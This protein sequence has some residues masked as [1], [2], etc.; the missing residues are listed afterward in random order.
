M[1]IG[2]QALKDVQ[3]LTEMDIFMP[4]SILVLKGTNHSR[5]V[6]P[7]NLELLIG[8]IKLMKMDALEVVNFFY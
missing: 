2:T 8:K 7:V 5:Y 1:R 4:V 3:V 6:S